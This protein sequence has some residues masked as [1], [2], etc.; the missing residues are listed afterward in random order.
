MRL[1]SQNEPQNDDFQPPP[2]KKLKES[3]SKL[4]CGT[5][6]CDFKTLSK[7]KMSEH[8]KTLGHTSP[9]KKIRNSLT[10]SKLPLIPCGI[11]EFE[12]RY[13]SNL[14][15]HRRRRNHYQNDTEISEAKQEEIR[16]ELAKKIEET[17]NTESENSDS[18]DVTI[19][20]SKSY[21]PSKITDYFKPISKKNSAKKSLNMDTEETDNNKKEDF[22]KSKT[23]NAVLEQ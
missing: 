6:N 2:S 23:S 17:K 7:L 12:T 13:H 1:L 10:P 8:R 3:S 5:N 9:S 16:D 18:E 11:C 20:L 19:E 14:V 4:K 15:R 22:V 21:S